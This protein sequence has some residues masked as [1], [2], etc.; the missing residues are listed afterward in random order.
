MDESSPEFNEFKNYNKY[1]EFTDY[2]NHNNPFE[3]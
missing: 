3:N 2:F 1:F